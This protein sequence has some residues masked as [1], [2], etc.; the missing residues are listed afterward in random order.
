[1]SLISLLLLI[2][3]TD[4]KV[5]FKLKKRTN[6][7]N[8]LET[9][10]YKHANISFSVK[11]GYF[12]LCQYN[13]ELMTR[14]CSH[15][16]NPIDES[17]G[18][19]CSN[20]LEKTIESKS[21]GDFVSSKNCI[22]HYSKDPMS[23][24]KCFCYCEEDYREYCEICRARESIFVSVP[25]PNI[26]NSQ[27]DTQCSSSCYDMIMRPFG[28]DLISEIGWNDDV[29]LRQL[30]HIFTLINEYKLYVVSN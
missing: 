12:G 1:M 2:L 25:L 18:I 15:K 19:F 29:K 14:P 16:A 21:F 24:R 10:I 7:N 26:Y 22:L 8:L 4:A 6:S 11:Y 28:L 17:L 5:A 9:Q 3:S 13:N 20:S 23:E 30:N 27:N